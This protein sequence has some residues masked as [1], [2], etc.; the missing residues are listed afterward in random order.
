MQQST[1]IEM[2]LN[3]KA[4][5]AIGLE[6]PASVQLLADDL[7]GSAAGMGLKQPTNDVRVGGSIFRKRTPRHA[8]VPM[9][10]VSCPC[11]P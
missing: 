5:T 2:V 8:I 6:V 7:I 10:A 4:A 9:T 11:E 1:R 3:L